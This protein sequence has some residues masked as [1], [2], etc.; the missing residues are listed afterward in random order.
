[1]ELPTFRDATGQSHAAIKLPEEIYAPI[2]DAVLVE[3]IER[4]I[5]KRRFATPPLGRSAQ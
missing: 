3:L 1:V 2:G 5:A 4:G